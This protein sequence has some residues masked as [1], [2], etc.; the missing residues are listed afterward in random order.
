[1][2]AR[3]P[4]VTSG[5]DT[6][7]LQPGDSLRRNTQRVVPILGGTYA[8]DGSEVVVLDPIAAIGSTTLTLPITPANGQVVRVTSRYTITTLTATPG[9]GQSIVG[10]P[11]TVGPTAPFGLVYLAA[12]T[13]WFRI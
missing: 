13:A 4:H 9:T 7:E 12:Q 8:L 3:S 10:A 5:G 6:V 11:T 1:M 2:T